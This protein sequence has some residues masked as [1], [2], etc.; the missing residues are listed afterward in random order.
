MSVPAT[1]WL[2]V[3]LV[4]TAALLAALVALVRHVRLLARALTRF[5]E[6][7][8]PLAAGVAAEGTRAVERA[9]GLREGRTPGPRDAR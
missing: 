9:A 2:V 4:T 7:V 8:A 1:V 3:G 6:D 5:H